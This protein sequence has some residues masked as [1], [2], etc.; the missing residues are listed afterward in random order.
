MHPFGEILPELCKQLRSFLSAVLSNFHR[1]VRESMHSESLSSVLTIVDTSMLK[2][3]Y[4]WASFP[5]ASRTSHI[6]GPPF[7][8]PALKRAAFLNFEASM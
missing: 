3:L 6:N 1:Y 8:T 4:L 2:M 7:P 5:I